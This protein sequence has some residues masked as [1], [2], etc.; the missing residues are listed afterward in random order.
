MPANVP[1]SDDLAATQAALAAAIAAVDA[2]NDSRS[3]GLSSALT[4]VGS[5]LTALTLRVDA[6]TSRVTDLE[7]PVEPTPTWTPAF[8]GD[9]APGTVRWG[10]AVGGNV[11]PTTRWETPAG[12]AFGVRRTFWQW[13]T[14]ASLI[15]TAKADL[16]KGRL[17]WV[18]TKVPSWSAVATGTYDAQVIDLITKLQALGKPVWLSVHH[19]PEG[20][21]VAADWRAMQAR[22]FDIRNTLKATNVAFAPI[23]MSWSWEAGVDRWRDWWAPDAADFIGI[24]HYA[25][26]PKAPNKRAEAYARWTTCVQAAKDAGKK[27]AVAEWGTYGTEAAIIDSY[28]DWCVANN[29]VGVAYFDSNLNAPNGSW[30]LKTPLYEAFIARLKDA[31]SVNV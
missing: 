25:D 31:R 24:D 1:T 30:E 18:S 26:D 10:A 8:A 6:L 16:A 28:Y 27:V 17:P 29:I 11:D 19:E 15:S 22:I 5:S 20:D 21:G 3:A 14:H 12:K 4:A 9:L 2:E 23:L 13:T 7:T